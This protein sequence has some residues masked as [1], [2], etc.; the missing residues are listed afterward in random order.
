QHVEDLLRSG[1][2][3]DRIFGGGFSSVAKV[4][5][6]RERLGWKQYGGELGPCLQIRYRNCDKDGTWSDYY[7][8]KPDR[9]RRRNPDDDEDADGI[10]YEAKKGSTNRAYFPQNTVKVLNDPKVP[11]L[12]VE[13]EKKAEKADQEGFPTI[14]LLGVDGWSKRRDK[15]ANGR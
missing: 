6:I 14:G 15:D 10:K 1:L 13:G 2:N 11:L 3:D 4:E 5:T 12:I 8:L 9:P 7:R